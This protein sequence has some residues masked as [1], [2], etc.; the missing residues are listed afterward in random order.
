MLYDNHI[1]IRK[2]ALMTSAEWIAFGVRVWRIQVN[3]YH[4]RKFGELV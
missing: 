3:P 2:Y 4:V 1:L